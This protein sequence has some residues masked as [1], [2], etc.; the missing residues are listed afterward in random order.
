MKQLIIASAITLFIL[1]FFSQSVLDR[2]NTSIS[3]NFEK[4]VM[5]EGVARARKEGYFSPDNIQKLKASIALKCDVDE[6]DITIVATTS[7]R[8]KTSTY[9]ESERITYSV[10]IPVDQLLATP[11]FWGI[12]TQANRGVYT[13][14]GSIESELLS[15]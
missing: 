1:S 15:N 2:R 6:D 5:E 9:N 14:K 8:Y 11:K 7:P 4:I 12:T 13:V 10:S 3:Q